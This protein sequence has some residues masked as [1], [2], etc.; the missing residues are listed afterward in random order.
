MQRSEFR[1]TILSIRNIEDTI[2]ATKKYTEGVGTMRAHHP[3]Q[4][5]DFASKR[6]NKYYEVY[7]DMNLEEMH[8]L[9]EAIYLT[10]DWLW[11]ETPRIDVVFNYDYRSGRAS[12]TVKGGVSDVR[13]LDRSI[14]GFK[15]ALARAGENGQ[16]GEVKP[17]LGLPDRS[18]PCPVSRP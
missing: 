11:G 13:E 15:D 10:S 4:G 18:R 8:S 1:G 2:R 17:A 9:G 16:A 5:E 6:F 3:I 14:P 12:M 7:P